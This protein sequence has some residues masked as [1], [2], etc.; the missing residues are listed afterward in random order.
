MLSQRSADC[1]TA[2]LVPLL[3]CRKSIGGGRLSRPG[4]PLEG[5]ALPSIFS[6]RTEALAA[7]LALGGLLALFLIPSTPATPAGLA[8]MVAGFALRPVF[9]LPILGAILPSYLMPRQIGSLTFSLPELV[10]VCAVAGALLHTSPRII[11]R[12]LPPLAQ[13]ATPFD[14]PIAL[15]LAAALTSLLASEL[16]RVSL[17][18]LRTL[19]LEPV[20]AFYL[21][22]WL[23][24]DRRD[25]ALLGIGVLAGGLAAAGLGLYQYFFTSHVVAVEGARRILGPYL[26][27]NHLGL[28]LGR[29]LPMA[30]AGALFLPRFRVAWLAAAAILTFAILLTFSLGAWVA[31]FFAAVTVFALWDGRRALA[32]AG[33]GVALMVAGVAAFRPERIVQHFSASGGTGFIRV[34]LWQSSLRMALDHPVLGVGLD[35]FLYHYR[36]SYLQAGASAEPNLSHPHNIFLQFWLQM[37][38]L[39]LASLLWLMVALFQLWRRLWAGA[40]SPFQRACLAAI[41]GA[42]VDLLLHGMVDNSYFLVDLAYQFWLAAGVLA[43]MARR[44]EM[45]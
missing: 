22:A 24:R 18:E 39:G 41:A 19:I 12:Q 23:V 43:V 6:N 8:M 4:R 28:Y 25:L 15:L 5:A 20:A 26:S 42:L 11:R 31:S 38:I 45:K 17:R 16:L 13:L 10:L 21:A 29:V 34:Q 32:L 2:A 14:G 9:A 1:Q 30:L 36:D 7:L 33:A 3:Y 44:G 27:P 37:G 35:N 40:P